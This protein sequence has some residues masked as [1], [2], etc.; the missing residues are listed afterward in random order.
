MHGIELFPHGTKREAP[1]P[2]FEI[3]RTREM[4]RLAVQLRL[5]VV[6]E[7]SLLGIRTYGLNLR[8]NMRYR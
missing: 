6:A 1:T 4:V 3:T 2:T 8:M 5:L 7:R